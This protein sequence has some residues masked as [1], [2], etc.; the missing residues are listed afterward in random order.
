M[1]TLVKKQH[2]NPAAAKRSGK[3]CFAV[4]LSKGAKV[5]KSKPLTGDWLHLTKADADVLV[6]LVNTPSRP[7]PAMK[8]VEELYSSIPQL[9]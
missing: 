6:H 9:G 2:K 7:N 1:R 5:K 4:K 3:R 8:E